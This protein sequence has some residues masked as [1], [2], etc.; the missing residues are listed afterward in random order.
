MGA[1]RISRSRRSWATR[2]LTRVAGLLA[3]A[4]LSTNCALRTH[5]AEYYIGPALF[6]YGEPGGNSG[7]ILQTRHIGIIAEIGDP[8]GVS[9]G[10]VD[11]IAASPAKAELDST[12]PS[13]D[14]RLW[15]SVASIPGPLRAGAW[16]FSPFFIRAEGLE[17]PIFLVRTVLGAQ[18]IGGREGYAV[19]VGFVRTSLL[20]PPPDAICALSY[21]GRDPMKTWFKTWH[22]TVDQTVALPRIL[23]D[24]RAHLRT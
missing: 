10:F 20:E 9:F 15:S 16:R 17:R 22:T 3:I 23:E 12:T 14:R 7:T 19:S 5:S 4:S 18:A 8:W 24:I 21:N 1:P 13:S 6:R 2:S 11:R